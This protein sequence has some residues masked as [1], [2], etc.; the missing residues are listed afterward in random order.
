M[1]SR[2]DTPP[3]ISHTIKPWKQ[4]STEPKNPN[5]MKKSMAHGRSLIPSTMHYTRVS[6]S[7]GSPTPIQST[8]PFALK[9]TSH[10]TPKT[11]ALEQH[12]TPT[13]RGQVQP[14]HYRTTPHANSSW[15]LN[16]PYVVHTLTDT[17]SPTATYSY[18]QA[19]S[20]VHT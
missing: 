10:M 7:N 12:L 18:C 8:S 15:P 16:M 1:N 11:S 13:R 4:N 20:I 5:R 19:G 17:P 2:T 3:S 6:T 14:W 9:H